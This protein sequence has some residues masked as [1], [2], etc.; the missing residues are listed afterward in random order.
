[1]SIQGQYIRS[2]LEYLDPY[3]LFQMWYTKWFKYTLMPK[4]EHG[5]VGRNST[6]YEKKKTKKKNKIIIKEY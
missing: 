3:A 5:K 2:I 1:M 6:F 4:P